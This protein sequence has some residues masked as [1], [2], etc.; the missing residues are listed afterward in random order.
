MSAG[1]G[2]EGGEKR[3]GTRDHETQP[4]KDCMSCRIIGGG[5]G[6]M[7]GLLFLWEIRR[8][9]NSKVPKYSYISP[10]MMGNKPKKALL[11]FLALTCFT[12]GGMRLKG[13]ELPDFEKT[14]Y[15]DMPEWLLGK[16]DD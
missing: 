10:R 5:A 13:K 8:M 15:H 16:T 9:K 4:L 12:V 1:G 7:A 3:N 6:C 11:I 14:I 2:T